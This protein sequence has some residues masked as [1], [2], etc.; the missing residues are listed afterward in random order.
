MFIVFLLFLYIHI[1]FCQT[2][3]PNL[4]S[5]C[6]FL[7]QIYLTNSAVFDQFQ[8]NNNTS[9]LLTASYAFSS[10]S[11]STFQLGLIYQFPNLNY[12]VPFPIIFDC[13]SIVRSCQLKT[14]PGTTITS[15]DS[16]PIHV[17]LTSFNY[18]STIQFNQMGLY[19]RQGQYQLSNCSLNN[20]QQMTDP[21]TIFHIQIQYEKPVG[22]KRGK[23]K[24]FNYLL[25]YK[26]DFFRQ[27]DMSIKCV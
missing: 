11:L 22:K 14:T 8:F 21:Q 13:A 19:L 2:P 5:N 24:D 18:T 9:I 3:T 1:I 4:I 12:L 27:I 7:N 20:G 15:R 23:K 26:H 17:D 10:S 6:S 25:G 16:E